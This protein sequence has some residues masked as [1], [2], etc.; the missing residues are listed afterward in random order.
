MNEGVYVLRVRAMDRDGSELLSPSVGVFMPRVTEGDV[1]ASGQSIGMIEVLG[2]RRELLVP[3]G[4]EGRVADR[5]G[6]GRARVAVQY[7]DALL[8][9]STTSMVN[10]SDADSSETG[11]PD[12]ALAFTAPMSGRFYSRPSP[13]EPPFVSAGDVVQR[14]QTLGL[15]EVM[16]TF[17]RLVYQG[18]ALPESAQV[19]KVVP[20]EGDDVVRGDVI[21]ALR[22]LAET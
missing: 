19:E 9:I 20:N 21:L 1:V 4:V 6:G 7:D 13:T 2:V 12:G 8:S 17:N 22:S 5:I 15:L 3:A 14:G 16:K 11:D 10:L 18:D